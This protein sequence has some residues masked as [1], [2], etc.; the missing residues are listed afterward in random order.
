MTPHTS[1][2]VTAVLPVFRICRYM[3]ELTGDQRPSTV[4]FVNTE[5]LVATKLQ[6]CQQNACM[7]TMKHLLQINYEL[8]LW[9]D[10]GGFL[11]RFAPRNTYWVT[12]A[13]QTMREGALYTLVWYRDEYSPLDDYED[14]L[15]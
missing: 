15:L 8:C 4:V 10:V 1:D 5:L 11:G 2:D 6:M 12:D 13:P 14:D 9:K 3:L 7:L